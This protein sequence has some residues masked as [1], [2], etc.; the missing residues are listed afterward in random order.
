MTVRETAERNEMHLVFKTCAKFVLFQFDPLP[1]LPQ[2]VDIWR[3]LNRDLRFLEEGIM[4][5]D[6]ML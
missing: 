3:R 6:G 1:V 4:N 5:K 2:I